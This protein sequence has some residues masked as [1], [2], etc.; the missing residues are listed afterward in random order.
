MDLM[1]A[2]ALIHQSK[3]AARAWPKS[4]Q[5]LCGIYRTYH[6]VGVECIQVL[7]KE[8]LH[9]V[10]DGT[11]VVVDGERREARVIHAARHERG[12]VAPPLRDRLDH[13]VVGLVWHSTSLVVH[14]MDETTRAVLEQ[15]GSTFAAT[16]AK[17]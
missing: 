3:V 16:H 2:D 9:R 8:V 17:T 14:D 1:E 12:V 7:L 6:E 11:T 4:W 13:R 15:A 10:R 5:P